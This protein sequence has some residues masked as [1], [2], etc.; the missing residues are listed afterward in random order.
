[1]PEAGDSPGA[2]PALREKLRIAPLVLLLTGFGPE[3]VAR[4]AN[5]NVFERRLADGDGLYLSGK[6][7]DE[8]GHKAVAISALH[9]HFTAHHG[10]GYAESLRDTFGQGFRAGGFEQN[11]VC[12][13]LTAQFSR[14]TQSHDLSFI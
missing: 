9:T 3:T 7:L 5:E 8:I 6:G 14:R 12:P 2:E 1:M 4:T 13:N 10:G 11:H